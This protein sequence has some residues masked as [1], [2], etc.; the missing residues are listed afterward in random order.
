MHIHIYT[1]AYVCYVHVHLDISRCTHSLVPYA[2]QR[3]RHRLVDGRVPCQADNPDHAAGDEGNG[4]STRALRLKLA[5]GT[6]VVEALGMPT[7]PGG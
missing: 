1:Y 7:E 3:H 5:R 4:L 2:L 6:G